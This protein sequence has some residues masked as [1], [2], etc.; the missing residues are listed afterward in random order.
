MKRELIN[1]YSRGA[2]RLLDLAC[3][4]GGDLLK[5]A[6]ADVQEVVGVDLSP[7][8]IEEAN[9]RYRELKKKVPAS[10]DKFQL[11]PKPNTDTDR[12]AYPCIHSVGEA[13]HSRLPAVRC[14]WTY[15]AYPLW[16]PGY[17]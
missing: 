13:D 16:S 6:D 3:G 2:R 17:A 5:W 7:K 1:R 9:R 15:V 14:A 4:R 10:V 11:I 12:S 8:E